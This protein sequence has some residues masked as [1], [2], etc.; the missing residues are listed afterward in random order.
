MTVPQ[1]L[2]ARM[3]PTVLDE[4]VGQD[5]LIFPGSPLKA[6][7][8]GAMQ[9]SVLLWGPPGT[10]KTTLAYVIGQST[11]K[12]FVELSATSA[13]VKDVREVFA[14]ARAA[15]DAEGQSTILFLDE[16]HRFSKSQQDI[17]LPAVEDGTISL[18]GATTENP[19]FSV[20]SALQSRSILL[21]LRSL[22]VPDIVSLLSR[23]LTDPR[24][25]DDTVTAEDSALEEIARLASGDTRQALGRLEVCA[26]IVQASDSTEITLDTVAQVTGTATQRYDRNG[27]QHYDVVSAWIKSM[28]GSDPQ[29]AV[30]WLARMLEAGEDPRF[31]VRRLIVHA[32]EDVGMADPTILPLCVAAAQ[33]VQ[34]VGLPEAGINLVHATIAVATAP[35][36]AGVIAAHGQA[37]ADV[38]RGRTGNVPKHLRDAHYPGAKDLGHG[39][40]YLYPHDFP[41]GLVGQDYMPEGVRRPAYYVPS[42]NG[43]EKTIGQRLAGIDSVVQGGA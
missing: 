41:H 7:V 4:V 35:K 24:G 11:S 17:L 21:V 5:H 36:S 16:I 23:A 43:F 37:L 38:K 8:E 34:L 3:R 22:E 13:A 19:S 12:R 2:A 29:A 39:A 1:P 31:I 25:L 28:R 30:H 10:G 33:A 32:S 6:I 26:Q 42:D 18:I 40:G 9:A 15:R 14:Q 20:I 27:D